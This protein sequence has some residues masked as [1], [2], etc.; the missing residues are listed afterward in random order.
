M[1][2]LL[3]CAVVRVVR[4]GVGAGTAAGQS[5]ALPD[6]NW[7]CT[8][9]EVT[10]AS[11]YLGDAEGDIL[12]SCSLGDTVAAT[13]WAEVASGQAAQTL[14]GISIAARVWVNGVEQ[15]PIAVCALD[16]LAGGA[17]QDVALGQVQLACGAEAMLTDVLLI[18]RTSLGDGATG[19]P[20]SANCQDY[21][22][23][24]CGR[25]P[26]VLLQPRTLLVDFDFEPSCAPQGRTTFRSVVANNLRPVSFAWDFGD[27]ST[28]TQAHPSRSYAAPGP[29]T[30]S[31]T[32]VEEPAA[33]ENAV[34]ASTSKSVEI[35]ACPPTPTL[36]PTPQLPT[37]TPAPTV[38]SLTPTV[39]A[40]DPTATRRASTRS[41]SVSTQPTATATP[42]PVIEMPALPET[43][44]PAGTASLPLWPVLSLGAG[45]LLGLAGWAFRRHLR[46]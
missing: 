31:L 40:P 3:L 35:G 44:P 8:S 42:E 25:Q 19:C 2:R 15:T 16:T 38:A 18:Y 27:G 13:V 24:S 10:I 22:P 26:Q 6:C 46:R 39:V 7:Q 23:A 4:L 17:S 33:T 36:T 45:S 20:A 11:F 37:A 5:P 43:L 14:Y 9:S 12:A 34:Q 32:V 21:T 30:V 28:S 29:Y 41:P 1:R